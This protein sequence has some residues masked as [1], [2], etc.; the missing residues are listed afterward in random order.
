[1]A[2]THPELNFKKAVS[3]HYGQFPPATLDYSS[4]IT[5]LADASAAIA[6][7]DQALK[8]VHNKEIL[9]APLRNQEAILS[10]RMEGT[11]SNMDEL[12]EYEADSEGEQQ[13]ENARTDVIETVMYQ[14]ALKHASS[15][16]DAGAHIDEDLIKALHARLLSLGRG[17]N[18][19]PGEYKTEQNLLVDRSKFNVTFIPVKPEALKSGMSTLFNYIKSSD[20]QILIRT[21]ISHVE[22]EALHPFK[23]GNGRIG[24]ML[25]TLMLWDSNVIS[26]PNF[27]ISRYFEQYKD[28]YVDSMREVSSNGNWTGWCKFF[29]GAVEHQATKNLELSESIMRLYEEMRIVFRDTLNSKHHDKALDFIFRNPVFRNN[30]FTHHAGIP[31]STAHSFIKTLTET[32]LLR[33]KVEPAGRRPGLYSFEPLLEIVR[34]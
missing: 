2:T 18:K 6:R 12:L 1:M 21:A 17:A 3:Y 34:V 29:L 8:K 23:D 24:R 16:I 28:L 13:N 14:R 32:K 20:A 26:S 11:I 5:P 31:A 33:T 30:R 7:Y 4:L 15:Q 19:S 22:F 9:V 25:I 27:Y 10:S